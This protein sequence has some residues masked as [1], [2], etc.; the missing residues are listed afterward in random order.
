[1]KKV[2]NITIAERVFFIEEDAYALLKQYLDA[3]AAHYS[4]EQEKV[5]IISDIEGAVAEHL[6]GMINDHKQ[7][8]TVGDVNKMQDKLG[9]VG[10]IVGE[11]VPETE[12]A[13]AKNAPNESSDAPKRLFRDPDDKYLAGVA[14]GL[15]A[16]FGIDPVI[17][18]VLFI[19]S[20]LFWGWGGLVYIVLWI[21]TP[22]AVSVQDKM[23][24]H[25]TPVT[26]KDIEKFVKKG[27]VEVKKSTQQFAKKVGEK[28][29][30]VKKNDSGQKGTL[31][32]VVSAPFKALGALL[33]GL[34]KGLASLVPV[35]GVLIGSILSLAVIISISAVGI[36][37]F[38][39]FMNT[40]QFVQEFN[41]AELVG[42]YQPIVV[43]SLSFAVLA[44]P[45]LLLLLAGIS[46]ML[47]KSIFKV[48]I[49]VPLIIIWIASIIG[50]GV[51]AVNLAPN[52][53]AI[54]DN[55]ESAP[56]ISEEQEVEEITSIRINRNHKLILTQGEQQQVTI[57]GNQVALDTYDV[58]VAGGELR[59]SKPEFCFFCQ[60]QRLTITAVVPNIERVHLSEASNAEIEGF[61]VND[62][63]LK[64]SG[65]AD[66]KARNIS[67][68]ILRLSLSGASVLWIDGNVSS[69]II[70]ASG[71]SEVFAKDLV[72]ERTEVDASGASELA[73][74][75]D[76][77]LIGKA[78]GA[79]EI[80]LYTKPE[81]VDVRTSG[82]AE[83]VQRKVREKTII[84]SST[85]EIA[86]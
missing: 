27:E 5:E 53:Q 8:V 38:G 60:G 73:L 35:I 48:A 9:S 47:R 1:M 67:A 6:S 25:G 2:T 11:E 79:S 69:S 22:E 41:I 81:F 70:S 63:E 20:T 31:R 61:Q 51:V 37:L 64:L 62:L 52:I 13:S 68:E 80:S 14:S 10:D 46:L 49:V 77:Q 17:V 66:A 34:G 85:E 65:A 30:T 42:T 55:I 54:H 44:I 21:A 83:V 28:V 84:T 3:I 36:F 7:A 12:G 29:Q 59:I 56:Q 39:F 33:E 19:I 50:A 32:A 71:A 74:S 4:D 16:Y 86:E 43:A 15:A 24:M 76:K 45:A 82:A 23:R 58:I 57:S 72:T 78:S 26:I 18:R 75:A 40:E